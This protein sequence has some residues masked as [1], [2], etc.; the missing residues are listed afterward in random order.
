MTKHYPLCVDL[1]GTLIYSDLLLESFLLLIKKNP[2]YLFLIPLWL[3]SGKAHLKAEITQRVSLNVEVLPYNRDFLEWL[4]EQKQRG[5]SLWLCTA[6]NERL[7]HQVA[8]HIGIFDGVLASTS[9]LNLSGKQ[10]A[11][12]L[13]ERFG[14]RGF[15][16]CGNHPVDLEV[17]R[18]ASR[19]IIVNAPQGLEKLAA[20]VSP[21]GEIFPG[22]P[23]SL[24]VLLKAIRLHQWAKNILVFV[25]MLAAHKFGDVGAWKACMWAFLAFGWC[26]SSVYILND[27]LDLEVDRQHAKKSQRA[28][29]SGAVP[30]F[31]GLRLIPVLLLGALGWAMQLSLAFMLTLGGYYLLTLGYSF[32]L[33]RLVLVDVIA[34]A[35]LYTV[36]LVAGATAV[37][38]PLSFWFLLFS[39]FLFLSLAL[40]KRYAELEAMRR[41]GKLNAAGRGYH[42]E[43]LPVLQSLG[44][45][46]GYLSVLVLGLYTN[47]PTVAVLYRNPQAIWLLSVL[48]LYWIS[49]IWMQTH[50]GKMHE[51]P[52][53]FAF[54]DKISLA[55]GVLAF[56]TIMIAI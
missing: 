18:H 45:S 30:I 9:T 38:V 36:R 43:D 53:V 23:Y 6:S 14:E 7:A 56:L 20:A 10:K 2:F 4:R 39:M 37:S 41:S 44:T 40:V 51:D 22:K 21:V 55:I 47:T 54:R 13:I 50:R 34:L 42:V 29:A 25:P 1:D 26:A 48:V 24:K 49:H 19:A 5:R 46:A 15:E 33:K 32:Y 27:L 11:A 35:A 28:F 31:T 8:D 12:Q 16:Y 52:V 17:W 3:W